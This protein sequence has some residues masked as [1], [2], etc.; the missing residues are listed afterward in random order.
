MHDNKSLQQII[1]E[2]GEN[3]IK[4]NKG[5]ESFFTNNSEAEKLI[6][7]KPLAYV[8]AVLYDQGIKAERAWEIPYLLKTKLGYFDVKKIAETEEEYL[9]SLFNQSPKLH[10]FPATMAKR[11]IDACK[12]IIRKYNGTPENIWND[13][14]RSSDLQSRF[15]EFNGIGQKKAS[16]ATNILVRDFG[17]E[18]KDKSGID[19]SY[20]IHI[21]RVFLRTGLVV[22]DDMQTI[23][24]TARELNP[25]YPGVLDLGCWVIGRDYCHPSKPD[26]INCPLSTLCPKFLETEN[27]DF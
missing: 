25:E 22:K 21:R 6:W 4:N 19:V 10:R 1:I 3:W 20:D 27:S 18:V 17:I 14:P 9:I 13:N 11:T 15:E 5:K 7:S 24:N 12:L 8:L 2:A 26:C 16:M 23:I